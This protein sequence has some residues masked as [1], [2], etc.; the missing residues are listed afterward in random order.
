MLKVGLPSRRFARLCFGSSDEAFKTMQTASARRKFG[1]ADALVLSLGLSLGLFAALTCRLVRLW[2]LQWNPSSATRHPK[3]PQG[4]PKG[5]QER[6]K[7]GSMDPQGIP[8]HPHGN[9]SRSKDGQL[10][11]NS[12][13]A[14]PRGD[15]WALQVDVYTQNF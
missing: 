2:R 10:E 6:S 4:R 15:P 5:V 9:L 8:R 3:T 7:T 12:V 14:G 13:I 1:F 11:P